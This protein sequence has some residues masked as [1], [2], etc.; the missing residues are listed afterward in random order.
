M[1]LLNTTQ[2]CN[3]C[4]L[5]VVPTYM[6]LFSNS[7]KEKS[8]LLSAWQYGDHRRQLHSHCL[9]LC[10]HQKEFPHHFWCDYHPCQWWAATTPAQHWNRGNV[11]SWTIFGLR[12][13]K[14]TKGN[15]RV[16]ILF[17]KYE[18]CTPNYK[19]NASFSFLYFVGL[20]L[21]GNAYFWK[22]MTVAG[23]LL[24]GQPR[25][26]TNP[27]LSLIP[28]KWNLMIHLPLSYRPHSRSSVFSL[29]VCLSVSFSIYL[30]L[31]VSFS[32]HLSLSFSVFLFL[33]LP[34]SLSAVD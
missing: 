28:T 30:F 6:Y 24:L 7:G 33:S 8:C 23:I 9:W 26:P 14:T 20:G 12:I 11:I 34:L 21:L 10:K 17:G 25:E 5:T 1:L 3:I 13:P 32:L 31:Y 27:G 16:L 29:S 15:S 2:T 4:N 18:I 19:P 22:T